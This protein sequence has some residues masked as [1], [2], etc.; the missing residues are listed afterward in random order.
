MEYLSEELNADGKEKFETFLK[1]QPEYQENFDVLASTWSQMDALSFPEPSQEMDD[2]FYKLLYAEMEKEKPKSASW[3]EKL[4]AYFSFVFRPQLAYGL[5]ILM[6]GLGLGYYMNTGSNGQPPKETVAD[7]KDNQEVRE[8]LVLTLLEQPS[9]NQRLQGVNEAVKFKEADDKV[10]KALLK[11]LNNDSNVNVR[12]AAIESLVN[13]INNPMVRE[14]LVASI[15]KQDSPIVQVTLADLMVALQ[16]KKSIAPFKKLMRT[17]ELNG[18]VKQ[19]LEKSIQ[20][21]I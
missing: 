2:T 16:E 3:V 4:Q 10:I 8:K 21:I 14:G 19:K 5:V 18:A 13:Y 7:V 11:T 20:K 17:Q 9:A 15:V 12:L 1:G 6:I